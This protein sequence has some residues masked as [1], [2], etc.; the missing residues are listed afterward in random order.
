MVSL[1][2]KNFL[3]KSLKSAKWTCLPNMV[4]LPKKQ[5]NQKKWSTLQVARKKLGLF[6][7]VFFAPTATKIGGKNVTGGKP[8]A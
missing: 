8:Y 5:K 4:S 7:A 6:L 1:A 2:K 3:A